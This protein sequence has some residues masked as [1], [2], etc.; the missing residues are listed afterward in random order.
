MVYATLVVT[1]LL[2]ACLERLPRLRFRRAPL[3]RACFAGDVVYL[4]TGFVAGTSLA[5]AYIVSASALLADWGAPRLASLDPP[6]WLGAALALVSLDAGNYAA[7]RLLHR[8]DVLWEI[9]KVHHSS[10]TLDWLATFRS[11]LLEQTL[12]RLMAP[13]VLIAIGLPLD[14]TVIGA[15]IFNAWAMLIHSNLRLDLRWLEPVLVTPRLHRIH[16]DPATSHRNFGTFLVLW[17]RMLRGRFVGREA[18]AE[19]RFGVPGEV[20]T[21]PQGWWSQ[22]TAP[23]GQRRRAALPSPIA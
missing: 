20:D 14:A 17:D 1:G 12:R 4:L 7:H 16:H 10:P 8:F 15:G 19:V 3:L 6:L 23:F 18:P 13:L 9:H 11:H 5:T 22:L 2:L 21:Y